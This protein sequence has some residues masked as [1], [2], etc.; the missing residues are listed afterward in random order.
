MRLQRYLKTWEGTQSENKWGRLFQASLL[1]IVFLLALQLFSK[2]YIVTIQPFTLT[3]EAWITKNN[4]SQSYKEA[5]GFAFAQIL[6]NIT[7]GSVD[8]VKE[9]IRPLLSPNIYQEVIDAI[10][11]Q[12]RQIKNDRVTMRFEPRFVEYEP[13]SEKVFVYGYSYMKGPSSDEQRSERTYEFIIEIAH[14]APVFAFI[15][16]Y[17]GKP[18]TEKVL[19]QLKH[20]EEL[21]K[22]H[23]QN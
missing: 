22:A 18:R 5:W 7:P 17:S 3:E 19:K 12:A 2:E 1:V 13:K 14:Y 23:D 6:G 21:Q 8:F 4:A 11:M 15:D 16:T 20:R 10:E 9:R